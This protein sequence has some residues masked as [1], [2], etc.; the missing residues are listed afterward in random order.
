[1][2][3]SSPHLEV[4]ICTFGQ[5]GIARVAQ[6]HHPRVDGVRYLVSWQM[7]EGDAA[8][9]Q[10]LERRDDF[11]IH[12]HRDRGLSRNRNHALEA[13][14]APLLLIADDDVEYT[15]S[16]LEGVIHAFEKYPKCDILCF[17]HDSE[18]EPVKNYTEFDLRHPLR[19]WY[20]TS[21]ELAMRLH[22][23]RQ[24]HFDERFGIGAP[25]PAG[26]EDVLLHT[27]L[28]SGISGRYLPHKVCM[29]R[30][31]TTSFRLET[32]EA[33][34][35]KG[36]VFTILHPLAWP[37]YMLRHALREPSG[38]RLTYIKGWL[39]GARKFRALRRTDN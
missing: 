21:F 5:E 11:K 1:M 36:A 29:H 28:R 15:A 14:S 27:M 7:P 18:E 35:I 22:V 33:A 8:V 9:P 2:M 25:F 4:L 3:D 39:R 30:G 32:E 16:S 19:G 13:A 12:T 17:A 6:C 31:L 26:E 10:E 20:L 37:A 24:V 38:R 34:K 23:A